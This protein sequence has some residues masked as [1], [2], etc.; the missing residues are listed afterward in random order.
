[1]SAFN[2][3]HHRLLIAYRYAIGEYGRVELT[4]TANNPQ[5]SKYMDSTWFDDNR[6]SVPWCSAFINWCMVQANLPHT[7]S[8][9]AKSWL[10]WGVQ[11]LNPSTGDLTVMQR[12][13]GGHVGFY[14]CS[15]RNRVAVLGGNQ[16]DSV[17]I[18]NYDETR[19]IEY[20]TIFSS[21]S[22]GVQA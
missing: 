1:M 14:V 16:N 10:D 4:G 22:H 6:D 2:P 17:C 19:V 18:K 5:I 13:G 11:T 12:N 21:H 3:T 7:D 15:G 9:R 8:P 20:R